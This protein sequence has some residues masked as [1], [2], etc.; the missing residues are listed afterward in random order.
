MGPLEV[1]LEYVALIGAIVC[2]VAFVWARSKFFLRTGDAPPLRFGLRP[3]GTIFGVGAIATLLLDVG[4]RIRGVPEIAILLFLCSFMVFAITV[5]SFSGRP[6][7]IA[8]TPGP[9]ERLLISGPYRYVRHPFYVS[10]ILFWAGVLIASP[11]IFTLIAFVVMLSLY[12]KAARFE[13]GE[14]L[15]SSLCSEYREYFS[16][17]GMFFP[18]LIRK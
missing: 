7:S 17:T 10:Y 14:I 6:P 15:S 5:R 1:F 4:A 3:L 18:K 13:E 11:S 12:I 8:F 9:P 2:L 16:R